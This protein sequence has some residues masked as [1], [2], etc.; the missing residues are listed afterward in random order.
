[1]KG[2]TY[3]YSCHI[4]HDVL[5]T[6]VVALRP[7]VTHFLGYCHHHR[8]DGADARKDKAHAKMLHLVLACPGVVTF[9]HKKSTNYA[10]QVSLEIRPNSCHLTNKYPRHC[11]LSCVRIWMN[12]ICYKFYSIP[13]VYTCK[14]IYIYNWDTHIP[15]CFCNL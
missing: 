12:I 13:L 10:F 15:C 7:L 11:F 14:S 5:P 6:E 4:R 9:A 8:H 3:Q 2:C 1:M